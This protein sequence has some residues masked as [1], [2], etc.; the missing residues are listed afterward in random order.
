[1]AS[2]DVSWSNTDRSLIQDWHA[3]LS[4]LIV[5]IVG[6]FAGK[7]LFT[8]H[9]E[10]LLVH[11]LRTARVDYEYGFQILHAVHAVESFL[12]RLKDRGCNFHVIWFDSHKDLCIPCGTPT[13]HAHKYLLTRAVLIQHFSRQDQATFSHRFDSVD[14][15]SFRQYLACNTQHFFMCSDGRASHSKDHPVTLSHLSVAYQVSRYG[16]CVAF[17]DE[18]SFTNSKVH[19]SIATPPGK[20]ASLEQYQSPPSENSSQRYE[21]PEQLP[22]KIPKN[23]NLTARE[24]VTLRALSRVLDSGATDARRKAVI[25][26]LL[27]LV[28][29]RHYDL[30]QRSFPQSEMLWDRSYYE[31]MGEFCHFATDII[32]ER[33]NDETTTGKWDVVDLF[34]GRLYLQVCSRFSHLWLPEAL[35]EE[36]SDLVGLLQNLTGIAILDMHPDS[37]SDEIVAPAKRHSNQIDCISSTVLPF[38]HPVVDQYLQQVQLETEDVSVAPYSQVF[39]ELTHWHN[40]MTPINPKHVP[41]PPGFFQRKRNQRF[42]ADTIAYSAS[43]SGATGKNI[44]PETIVVVRPSPRREQPRRQGNLAQG[45]NG[46][47]KDALRERPSA[48]NKKKVPKRGPHGGREAALQKAEA[49]NAAKVEEKSLASASFWQD[50]CIEFEKEKSLIKRFLKVE[51]YFSGLSSIQLSVIGAE[52]SLYSCRILIQLA[53]S[54]QCPKQNIPVIDAM[55]WSKII[56]M[57]EMTLTQE[58]ANQLGRLVEGLG[59]PLMVGPASSLPKR[60]LPFTMGNVDLKHAPFSDPRE[61]QLGNFGPYMERSFDSAP[62]TRVPFNPDAWQ[63]KI[64]D[65]IDADKSLFVVAPTSAGKTFIS[66]YAMKKALQASNDDIVVYVAPTKALVNQ[67]AAEVQARFSKSYHNQ[68]G[69]SV[70]AIHT[71]DYRV[72]NPQGC[73]VLVTVPHILQIM[74]LAPSNAK[75]PTSWSRRVRRIIFDEVHCI[76]QSEDGIIWEQL[77]LLAPCPIIALS[78]TVGNPL[79]FKAWLEGT[80]RVKGF[81]LEMIVHS[82]R[83]SDLRKYI[84]NVPDT[85]EFKGLAPVT[86]LPFPGLESDGDASKRFEFVHPVGALIGKN[87]DTLNDTSLEPRDCLSLWKCL[88][89]HENDDYKVDEYLSPENSLP[90]L[91][92]KSDVVK[93]EASLKKQIGAWMVDRESPFESIQEDLR[94]NR[95]TELVQSD[96]QL[97]AA[98]PS[99]GRSPLVYGKPLFSL[100]LDLRACG[101]LPAIFFNYD[102]LGCEVILVT[103]LKSLKSAED[104]YQQTSPEWKIKIAEFEKWKN[105]R[106]KTPKLPRSR[107]V[108]DDDGFSKLDLLR[109]DANQEASPWDSFDP[110]APLSQFSFADSTKIS[111]TELEE[112]L[113]TLKGLPIRPQVIEALRRGLGI[114]HAGMNRQ[115]RQVVEMLFRKGYLTVVVATGTLALGIN[116]P[117]KTVVFAGDSA[118]LT[119]LNYRQASGRAGRRGFDVLG[120]VVFHGIPPKRSLEIMSARLPDLRGQFPISVTL[121]LRLFGLLHGTNNSEYATKAVKSLL[122][123]TR[124]YL[125]GPAAQMS[126]QHHLRFSIDYLRRQ[127]LLSED[128]TPLNFSGLVGHLY[129]TENAAF[130]F[131]SL[132]KEGYFHKLCSG[133]YQANKQK[134]ILLE[135]VLVLSHLF[136]RIPCHRYQDKL[137]LEGVM[138][139]SPSLILL[140]ELPQTA[141]QIL[142]QHNGE[143]LKVFKDYVSTY[144]AQHLSDV[145]DAE[146]PFTKYKVEPCKLH[147]MENILPSLSKTTVRSSFAALSGFTDEF[148]TIEELCDTVRAGIFLEKSA[149]PY[150]PIAPHETNG[151]PWNAYIYDFF[152]HGDMDAL[153]RDNGIKGGDVWFRLKDFSLILATI[154]TSLTNFLNPGVE[155][156]DAAMIDVQDAGD[157]LEENAGIDTDEEQ[158]EAEASVESFAALRIDHKVTPDKRKAKKH[159]VVESWDAEESSDSD[160]LDDQDGLG[161][162]GVNDKRKAQQLPG[163]SKKDNGGPSWAQDHGASLTKVHMAFA[164]LS[165]QFDEKFKKVWA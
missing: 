9:G 2:S 152:K 76:G 71:R 36:L 24:L 45:S 104:E 69:R 109:E 38:S 26:I 101:A 146:L 114:H 41:R 137:W 121:I 91:V 3:S 27:H 18:I 37:P 56:G 42:M 119:A 118:F 163:G 39:Q 20:L 124:L 19:I 15:S 52:V 12:S 47:W 4:P 44:K 94:G 89:R 111:N 6:D 66:F 148:A 58:I 50:R 53:H 84:Y 16:Y 90:S 113:D 79:E 129:F 151:V 86:R 85:S 97:Q 153:V 31:V 7:E 5:D 126:I 93:W 138:H 117:C 156:D 120:N 135:I 110:D 34:D 115:Y 98:I 107:Q 165:E 164:M 11:S 123:Q 70:W 23:M 157:M 106:T 145:A 72:N 102:R 136:C 155:V 139:R 162:A 62:D 112:R 127:H 17:M 29:L 88:K 49:T 128:G 158:R 78:A 74:L 64:L 59:I 161:E 46:D 43:L 92:K 130:A 57:K 68:E 65:A 75:T 133:I 8:I 63:R 82:S 143:T 154:K 40:A 141:A 80:Q 100:A 1:M 51:K 48:R 61:F 108:K 13:E 147:D 22:P 159:A 99:K 131:H 132:L 116:M 73:Q 134:D 160:G 55:L 35:K 144:T 140:P 105:A 150:I 95:F 54:N 25:C 33:G 81:D 21:Q 28:L 103:L 32:D 87:L 30:S 122:T 77:L 60:K 14:C 149:I 125:G 142:T 10:A 67:I 96:A 83:Y